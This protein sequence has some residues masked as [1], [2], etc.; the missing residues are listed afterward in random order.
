MIK[1]QNILTE[2][3]ADLGKDATRQF[4]S[5]LDDVLDNWLM[6]SDAESANWLYK[7]F[8]IFKKLKTKYPK[9]FAP[10]LPNGTK[11]YRGLTKPNQELIDQV[12]KDKTNKEKFEKTTISGKTWYKYKK[13]INYNPHTICQSWSQDATISAGYIDDTD[14]MSFIL[15]TQQDDSFLFNSDFLGGRFDFNKEL[16]HF[17]KDFPKGVYLLVKWK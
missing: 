16:I 7:N 13:K 5:K 8:N 15:Q 17:G 2:V 1:L 9:V 14:G 6:D 10:K 3:E 12:L 11:L 4:Q